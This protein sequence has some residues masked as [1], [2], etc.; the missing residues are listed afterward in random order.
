MQLWLIGG[1]GQSRKRI[2]APPAGTPDIQNVIFLSKFIFLV[3]I[4]NTHS[5]PLLVHLTSKKLILLQML[6]CDLLFLS[7]ISHD[8]IK[9]C[10]WQKKSKADLAILEVFLA[11]L[12]VICSISD[13]GEVF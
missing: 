10:I 7:N 12:K 3:Q 4:V 9:S 11:Q 1:G 2:V 5:F 8:Q 6:I 13:H